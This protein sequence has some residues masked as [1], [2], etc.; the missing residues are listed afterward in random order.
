MPESVARLLAFLSKAQRRHVRLAVVGGLCMAGA[1]LFGGWSFATW[2]ANEGTRI[3][4]LLALAAAG[5]VV[6]GIATVRVRQLRAWAGARGQAR[7]V[8]TLVPA[9]RGGLLTV[10]DRAARPQGSGALLAR[11]AR[12]IEPAVRPWPV[13]RVWPWSPL[14]RDVRWLLLAVALFGLSAA[15]FPVGPVDALRSLFWT[16]STTVATAAVQ[17]SGPRAV[18]GDITLRYL[19][20]TYTK[21]EPLEVPNTNGEVHAPP[22]TRVEVRARTLEAWAGAR[23]VAYGVETPA[24]LVDG[25]L[26]SGGFSVAGEGI[27]RFES[28]T[29]PTPDYRIVPDPDLPPTVTTSLKSV[30]SLPADAEAAF[31]FEAKDDYGMTRVV[32]EVT[33]RGEVT[34]YPL[35]TP[36]DTPLALVDAPGMLVSELG[37]GPGDVAKVRIGA[38]DNDDVGGSKPGWTAPIELRIEGAHGRIAEQKRIRAELL[39]VLLP[40]LAD[41]LV[42]AS[43]VATSAEGVRAYGELADGRFVRF[44]LL[45]EGDILG[46]EGRLVAEVTD[47]RRDLVAFARS[48]SAR[49][50]NPKDAARL[51][52]LHQDNVETL[53]MA[54][55]MLDQLQRA[56]ASRQL[57][58]LVKQLAKEAAELRDDLPKLQQAQ[59]LARLDQLSRLWEQVESQAKQLDADGI[60]QF[61]LARGAELEGAMGAAR[62]DIAKGDDATAKAD[63]ERVAQLLDEMAGGVE[64]ARK[65]QTGSGDELQKEM[66]AVQD[67]LEALADDQAGLHSKTESARAKHG[68][69]LDDGMKAWD[70]VDKAVAEVQ[71]QLGDASVEAASAASGAARSAVADAK[72]DAEGLSDSTRARDAETAMER[73][74][75]LQFTLQRAASRVQGTLRNGD[76]DAQTAASATARLAEAQAAVDE[77]SQALRELSSRAGQPSP[78]LQQALQQLA[79]EQQSLAERAQ[80]AAERAQRLGQSMPVDAS[81]MG[82]AAQQGAQEAGR[83]RAALEKGDGMAAEGGQKSAEDAF[84][85]ALDAM[86]QAKND[87]FR[88]Q[89]AGQGGQGD[90]KGQAGDEDGAG[91]AQRRRQAGESSNG[92]GEIKIPAPEEV[93]T[94]EEYRQALLEGMQ[95]QVPE[96][97]R[98]LNRRYYEELVRQ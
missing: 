56:A 38:W 80:S 50:M 87:M 23:M 34:E 92:T 48:L 95:G 76:V 25:R 61:L 4:G 84:R 40:L 17:S 72:H 32:V 51:S 46:F 98:A 91:Q 33:V 67:E 77:A 93:Q 82:E 9:L 78:Q 59:A 2:A 63:M 18:L 15:L 97:Y 89:Q 71:R 22:G 47:S 19:Y 88:L 39:N 6:F 54:V 70:K 41:F 7:R 83:A 57:M 21:L 64:E 28:D 3:G 96:A 94:P 53:E 16:G 11:L 73:A 86:D 62:R 36:V 65:R 37:L 10:V 14:L 30:V 20:P 26:V 74:D 90:A 45:A 35:R 52:V 5:G 1:A 55:W 44:D 12:E 29:L 8:E 31:P 60:R 81:K 58:D 42:D 49:N 13:E 69:K 43:P 24:E 66:A 75:T 85:R 27:W 79:G 68:Q